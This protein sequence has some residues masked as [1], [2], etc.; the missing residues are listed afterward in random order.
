M[1]DSVKRTG[2]ELPDRE[3]WK[4][5]AASNAA[6]SE[7]RRQLGISMRDRIEREMAELLKNGDASDR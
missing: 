3:P 1:G 6:M 7:Q 4:S 2:L 5:I